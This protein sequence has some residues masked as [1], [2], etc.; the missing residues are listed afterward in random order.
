MSMAVLD[1]LDQIKRGYIRDMVKQN[2]RIDNRAFDEYR[3][4]EV[5]QGMITSA[6]GSARARIGKSEVLVGVK[7]G[8]GSPF[9]DR[10]SEGILM[11]NAE[12]LPLA[13]STFESGPPREDS[14]ELAR[15]VDRGIR[16]ANAVDIASLS[17]G[18]D[19]EGRPKVW[20]T[21]LDIYVIDHDGNLQDAA[22]LAAMS[23]ILNTQLPKYE[24]GQ[25][26][27]EEK[28]G[29]LPSKATALSCTFGK[30]ADKIILD[31]CYAEEVSLDSKLT[32]ATVKDH[33]CA[34]QKSGG[35]GL[36][37][38]ELDYCM[39]LALKKGEE[40]RGKLKA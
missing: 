20:I 40:L 1:V 4:V 19:E 26:V 16:S 11:T 7:I 9:P 34:C 24:D 33:I 17:L 22:G 10:P 2:K 32:I 3:K 28:T 39:D 13:S 8:V 15:V 30:I 23:A 27:R 12:F 6:E 21:F 25:I 29:P 14:I 35:G 31:P 38:A 36:S 18:E 37:R 5:E